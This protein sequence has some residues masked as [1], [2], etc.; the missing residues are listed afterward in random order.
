M[1]DN[2][3]KNIKQGK[4]DLNDEIIAPYMAKTMAEMI[5]NFDENLKPIPNPPD[6]KY[7]HDDFMKFIYNCKVAISKEELGGKKIMKVL[8]V[9]LKNNFKN[10]SKPNFES[11]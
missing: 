1:N 6:K 4:L 9:I 3:W 11:F 10:I 2:I 5:K 7:S 8:T